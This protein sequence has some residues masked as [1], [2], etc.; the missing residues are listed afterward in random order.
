MASVPS[1][2]LGLEA[3]HEVAYVAVQGGG[4]LAE[5]LQAGVALPS[6]EARP[7]GAMQARVV[8]RSLLGEAERVPPLGN[9][10]TQRDLPLGLPLAGPCHRAIP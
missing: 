1:A 2:L 5:G 8:R 10:P 9:T 4:D 6:F 7:V 3:G